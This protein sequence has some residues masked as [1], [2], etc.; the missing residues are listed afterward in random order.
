MNNYIHANEHT[1]NNEQ[2][3]SMN[4]YGDDY[5]EY[6]IYEDKTVTQADVKLLQGLSEDFANAFYPF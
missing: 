3:N 5:I 4:C 1:P 2:A 6:A